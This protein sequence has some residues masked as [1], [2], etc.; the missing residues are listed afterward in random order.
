MV[1][2]T[3]FETEVKKHCQSLKKFDGKIQSAQYRQPILIERRFN[4]CEI[5]TSTL[6]GRGTV[7]LPSFDIP[8]FGQMIRMASFPFFEINTDSGSNLNDTQEFMYL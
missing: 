4:L 7:K 1:A 3:E 5:S 2:S 8:V 6:S